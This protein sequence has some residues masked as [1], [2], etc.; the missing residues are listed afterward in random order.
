MQNRGTKKSFQW[1]TM[2]VFPHIITGRY[3]ETIAFYCVFQIGDEAVG[4]RS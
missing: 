4:D 3:C 2:L 1:E